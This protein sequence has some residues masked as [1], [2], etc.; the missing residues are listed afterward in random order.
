MMTNLI[1]SS[2][3][4]SRDT[5]C[6]HT[7]LRVPSDVVGVMLAYVSSF[8]PCLCF[9]VS[10]D[11]STRDLSHMNNV[12]IVT[13]DVT[14]RPVSPRAA[15][16]ARAIYS[17]REVFIDDICTWRRDMIEQ[18]VQTTSE[19]SNNFSRKQVLTTSADRHRR[20]CL[21]TRTLTNICMKLFTPAVKITCRRLP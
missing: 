6:F 7:V 11:R 10:S 18:P 21:R 15:S 14:V 19:T 17:R 16:A 5:E 2:D 8:S 20:S 9:R 4:S 3:E 12:K 1:W 13:L